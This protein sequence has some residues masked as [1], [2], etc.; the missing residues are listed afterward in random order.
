MKIDG[1]LFIVFIMALALIPG[2]C[3]TISAG[4]G[5][6]I[7]SSGGSSASG[8]FVA[9]NTGVMG[10]ASSTGTGTHLTDSHWVANQAGAYAEIGVDI[11][12]AMNPYSYSYSMDPGEGGGKKISYVD[13]SENLNVPN[14]A[15]IDAYA[16]SRNSAGYV[17]EAIIDVTGGSLLGYQN[18]ARASADKV[19]A[20][21]TFQDATGTIATNSGTFLWGKKN[22]P[23]GIATGQ[24]ANILPET[25]ISTTVN[26]ELSD[27][28]DYATRSATS[29][30]TKQ[31]GHILGT[32]TSTATTDKGTIIRTTPQYGNEYDLHML[33]KKGDNPIG[34]LGLYVDPRWTIQGAVDAALSGDIINV[35]PG[36]YNENVV[37]Y[38]SVTIDG[39][40]V[41]KTIVNGD[42]NGDTVG[43][44][45]V[46][47]IG[48]ATVALSDMTI[49][50]GKAQYGAGI[51]IYNEGTL[52]LKNI[53]ITH[54]TIENYY[55]GGGG[56]FN[57]H[58]TVNMYAGSSITDNTATS[59]GGPYIGGSCGGG[60]FNLLGTVNMYA[61]SSITDNTAS[62]GGGGIRNTYGTINMYADSS[63][64]H[65]RCN[66]GGGG[67]SNYLGT[68]NMYPG[69]SI[70]YNTAM[71]GG[72]M[73]S[74][75]TVDMYE[76]S[77][78]TDNA[79]TM[80]G[81]GIYEQF[82][83]TTTFRDPAGNIL[84]T[85]QGYDTAN[86]P[87]GFFT[88]HNTPNDIVYGL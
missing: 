51:Y 37:V 39:A 66:F 2:A 21:Q 77:S 5:T 45:S 49:T 79:A 9:S 85:W 70:A 15:Q 86:D 18:S 34:T 13:A 8:N 30:E 83:G 3:A 24:W 57:E 40:G 81:G 17:A 6:S 75:G 7:S 53:L 65:N 19:D 23:N 59:G 29:S 88:P 72:G 50:N 22:V 46:F 33:A 27:Y 56:I 16:R 54:N 1:R 36:I 52:N 78:I 35:K 76:G 87:Y 74:A 60:I 25:G 68:L 28:A 41:D 47:T 73:N 55:G 10:L 11:N 69:S 63:I 58:G 26:G 62:F 32:L 84:A 48:D 44:G 43:D 64:D 82:D 14:A 4:G 12:G 31:D 80:N 20:S 38:K 71:L 67:I 61:G 42:T